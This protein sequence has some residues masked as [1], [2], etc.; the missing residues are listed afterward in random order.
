MPERLESPRVCDYCIFQALRKRAAKECKS[1]SVMKADENG[2]NI[3]IH[4]MELDIQSLRGNSAV[5]EEHF[6]RWFPTLPN[7]CMCRDLDAREENK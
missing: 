7:R 4:S 2:V 5:L 1:L 3:Y 6:V